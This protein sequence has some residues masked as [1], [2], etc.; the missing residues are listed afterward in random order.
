M[1]WG[2]NSEKR[3]DLFPLT[4]SPKWDFDYTNVWRLSEAHGEEIV[5]AVYLDEQVY[6]PYL[7]PNV[8]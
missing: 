8:D 5:R 6:P 4:P 2:L 7:T 1:F 3:L